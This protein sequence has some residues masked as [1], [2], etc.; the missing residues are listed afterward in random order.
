VPRGPDRICQMFARL[1]GFY[2]KGTFGLRAVH[3]ARSRQSSRAR[4]RSAYSTARPDAWRP[5]GSPASPRDGAAREEGPGQSTACGTGG[6][7]RTALDRSDEDDVPLRG[8]GGVRELLA[9]IKDLT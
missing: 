7:E 2:G 4:H 9:G 6:L 3:G 1:P 5:S 8:E